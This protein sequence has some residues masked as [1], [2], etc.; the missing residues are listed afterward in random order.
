MSAEIREGLRPE[1][2]IHVDRLARWTLGVCLLLEL[3]LVALDLLFTIG[4]ISGFRGFRLLFDVTAEGG[5][6]NWFSSSQTL[7]V[8]FIISLQIWR[9]RRQGTSRWRLIGWIVLGLFFAYMAVDDGAAIHERLGTYVERLH[10]QAPSAH[11][12]FG[13]LHGA[14]GSYS[15][16]VVL[17]PLFVAMGLFMLLFLWHE[18]EQRNLRLLLVLGLACLV[19]AVGLD[20]VEGTQTGYSR[21][22]LLLGLQTPTV[23]H[24]CNV[25][26]ELAEM[27][28]TSLLLVAL[29]R[30]L[31]DT[32][33]PVTLRFVG[34]PAGSDAT[35]TPP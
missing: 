6:G 7:V 9:L 20:H 2:T 28:G 15:W 30:H 10:E 14:L 32:S 16:Q 31:L 8:A 11:A 12:L 19:L 26:E 34:G 27:F 24:L 1:I 3:V 33:E 4:N 35:R 29:L 21:L 23:T 17:G 22:A 13:Q 5:L 25:L 18:L